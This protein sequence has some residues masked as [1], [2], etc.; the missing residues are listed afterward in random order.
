MPAQII[1]GR[2]IAAR[3]QADLT[4]EIRLFKEQ[5]GDVPGL[6]NLMATDS[7]GSVVYANAQKRC[8]EQLGIRYQLIRLE[9]NVTQEAMLKRICQCNDDPRIN[10]IMLHKPLPPNCDY[11]C[12]ARAIFPQK[13]VEGIHPE[14]MGQLFAGQP[15]IVPC[16]PAAVMG[17]LEA[18][19]VPLYGKEAVVVGASEIIGR[20]LSLM[21]LHRMATV[22]VCHI[23]TSEAGQLRDHVRRADIL[24]VAVG[25]PNLIPGDWIKPGAVVLDVGISNLNGQMVGDVEFE[26]AARHAAYITPVPGGIGPVTVMILM[27]N[28][29]RMFAAQKNI[30]QQQ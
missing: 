22:T 4:N 28:G 29:V 30:Q 26:H 15:P 11:H 14:N 18:T 7:A 3:I 9:P 25:H 8:A 13:D 27:R 2:K 21:L 20:P 17:C 5:T 16:T 24:I 19:G 12:L 6:V 1:D 10:G 23:A